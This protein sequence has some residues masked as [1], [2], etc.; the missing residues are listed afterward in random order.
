MNGTKHLFPA[1]ACALALNLVAL[2]A[3]LTTVVTC[4]LSVGVVAGTAAL[5]IRPRK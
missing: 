5:A 1:A 3:E 2:N 4:L